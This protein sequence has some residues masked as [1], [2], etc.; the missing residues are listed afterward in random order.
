MPDKGQGKGLRMNTKWLPV[1]VLT[2][3]VGVAPSLLAAGDVAPVPE[4]ASLL[5]L[6]TGAG[7]VGL[8]R[9][10]RSKK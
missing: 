2:L 3:M 10:I 7:A 5:L 1:W 6:A 4:P 8:W 9:V